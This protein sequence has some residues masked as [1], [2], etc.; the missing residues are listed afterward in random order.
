MKLRTLLEE[1]WFSLQTAARNERCQV[2]GH[3]ARPPHPATAPSNQAIWQLTK[4]VTA[5]GGARVSAA[6]P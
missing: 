1:R 4:I 2:S 5:C 3:R 6:L